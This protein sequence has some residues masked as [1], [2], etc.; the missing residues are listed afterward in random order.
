MSISK[1]I[2]M[3][4]L[5]LAFG[6]ILSACLAVQG[7]ALPVQAQEAMG[8]E[9]QVGGVEAFGGDDGE[10]DGPPPQFAALLPPPSGDAFHMGHHGWGKD[11]GS[12]EGGHGCFSEANKLTD[13]QYEK[14]YAIKEDLMDQ[15][16][17][18]MVQ[19]HSLGR[20][21]K[22]TLSASNIDTKQAQDLQNKISALKA[23]MSNLKI[24]SLIK[25]A[26]VLTPEQ[27]KELRMKMIKASLGGHHRHHGHHW[28]FG[29]SHGHHAMMGK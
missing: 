15:M 27:R 3:P 16:G 1:D 20:K 22:D 17:P 28:G 12:G 7:A 4:Q 10:S 11:G 5:P 25:M 26:Q 21:L 24:D 19:S 23:D 9:A 13:D 2:K 18:K 29:S 8:G 14:L 6:L